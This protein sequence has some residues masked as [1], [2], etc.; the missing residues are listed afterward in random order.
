MYMQPLQKLTSLYALATRVTVGLVKCAKETKQWTCNVKSWFWL[1]VP[2]CF[3]EDCNN[4]YYN[5]ILQ[6][7]PLS[8]SGILFV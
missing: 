7:L 3:R 6:N 8:K 5:V 1:V 4:M 2:K